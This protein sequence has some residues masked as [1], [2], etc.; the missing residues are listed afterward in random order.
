MGKSNRL[1][2]AKAASTLAAPA[3]KNSA[4]K[5][6]PTWVGTAIIVAVL[7]VVVVVVTLSV[8]SSRGT[9][10]RMR[11]IAETENFEVTVPMMSYMLYTEYQNLVSTYDNYSQQF[12]TT[13]QIPAADK[14]GT[15]LDTSKKLRDQIYQVKTYDDGST[16]TVTWFDHFAELAQKDLKEILSCCEYA[17]AQGIELEESELE[18][19]DMTIDNLELY[20]TYYGYTMNAYLS[21]MYGEGVLAKDVRAMMRLTELAN[22]CSTQRSKELLEGVT[23]AAVE[24]KYNANV[25]TYD[26]YIDYIGYSFTIDF[27]PT[28]LVDGADEKNAELAAKYEAKKEKVAGYI[29]QLEACTTPAEFNLKLLPILQEYFLEE[30]K[31]AALA[32]KAAGETL[33]AEELQ[34]CQR[35]AD[36]LAATS[37]AKATNINYNTS[38]GSLGADANDWLSD[39]TTPRVENEKKTFINKKDAYGNDESDENA[40]NDTYTEASSTYEIYMTMSGLHRNSG[41]VRS[42]GHILFKTETF[43]KVTDTS[44]LTASQKVLA[45]RILARGA[46]ISAKEMS[47]ELIKLMKEEGKLT[48]NENGV[49]VMDSA[50]FQAYGTTYTEDSNVFY[51]NVEKG[52]M[53]EEFENW[54]FD[55]ARVEGE[56]SVEAVGTSHGYHVMLYR[57]DEKPAWSYNIRNELAESEYTKWLAANTETYATTFTENSKYWDMISG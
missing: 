36:D 4:K 44:K 2:E 7:A 26:T 51:D 48:Q 19:I 17:L 10:K 23:D 53:V 25:S 13:I 32:K 15:A 28:K 1:K 46:T 45:D 29:A 49:W 54:L 40:K 20:A 47:V 52:Q 27:E 50:V 11:V 22:K 43:S 16:R 34:E 39:T 24:E 5:A 21:S 31:E 55:K 14:T 41:V 57:A 38:G 8:L 6:M 56:V 18:A 12:G 33:T 30:Q 42:V 3:K 37:A 9:F 35:L